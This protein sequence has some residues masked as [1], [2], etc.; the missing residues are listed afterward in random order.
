MID[1]IVE[2]GVKLIL[3]LLSGIV[4]VVPAIGLAVVEIVLG[5]LKII[6]AFLPR[7]IEIGMDIIVSLIDGFA[8]KLPDLILAL[9]NL[10]IQ[11]I[12]GLSAALEENGPRF[13]KAFM[14]LL[15]EVLILFVVAGVEVIR[16]LFG[17][18]PGGVDEALTKVSETAEGRYERTLQS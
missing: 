9:S 10:V 2:F 16:A 4:Q 1:N 5:L 6:A 3:A 14:T 18:I 11:M 8:E 12:D 17:W 15:G 7:F 13:I